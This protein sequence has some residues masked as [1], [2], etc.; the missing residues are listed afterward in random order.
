MNGAVQ[1]IV[2]VVGRV[3][4]S[5]IFLLSAVGNKIP[6]FEDVA[7]YM[8]SAGV[9]APRFLLACAI[10]FLVVG[11][12]SLILGLWARIG[13][14]LLLVFLVLATYYFHAFW[15]LEGQEA[16]MQQI[17]FMKNAALMGAMLFVM[18]NGAGHWS[19]DQLASRKTA[20]PSLARNDKTAL[21]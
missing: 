4:L 7:K 2:S 19:L 11:S 5:G 10:A 20:G 8:A 6:N 3:F 17:Q 13:A 12:V 21:A 14:G 1:G 9:P 18:A 16:A 15:T